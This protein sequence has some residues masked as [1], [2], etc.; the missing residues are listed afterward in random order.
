MS[1]PLF[2]SLIALALL[3]G[4]GEPEDTRPGQPVKQR[5]T[6]FKDIL[7]A[8]EPMGV[9]LREHRYDADKFAALADQLA[10]R[11]DGP[12]SHFGPDTLYPPSKA[13]AAVWEKPADFERERQ[14]FMAAT[15]RL[16]EAAGRRQPA[17]V[18]AAY[19]AVHE[20]CQNCHRGFKTR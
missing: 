14:A 16:Q 11:R 3:A 4:C 9:M 1:R 8:F 17:D 7:K 2:V 13:T 19:Q 18:E 10:A 12:W 15:I 20:S 6:A 5:Q